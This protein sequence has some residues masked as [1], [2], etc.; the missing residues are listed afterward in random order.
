MGLPRVPERVMKGCLSLVVSLVVLPVLPA[1]W[2]QAP[3]KV[4]RKAPRR[5]AAVSNPLR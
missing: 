3:L 2:P 4:Q 5:A 1:A